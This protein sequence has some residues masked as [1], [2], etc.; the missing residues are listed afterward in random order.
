MPGRLPR[1]RSFLRAIGF[2][3]HDA[4]AA[5]TGG[6][7]PD[8]FAGLLDPPVP[9]SRRLPCLLVL[10]A[11][12]VYIHF[13][14]EPSTRRSLELGW[15]GH[16]RLFRQLAFHRHEAVVLRVVRSAVTAETH[17]VARRR[18]TVVPPVA[19]AFGGLFILFRGRRSAVLATVLVLAAASIIDDAASSLPGWGP[20]PRLL[21]HRR[22]A[23]T[24]LIG[25]ALG[26]CA[27]PP[28]YPQPSR[29][30]GPFTRL[31]H[32]RATVGECTRSS[33]SM[34]ATGSSI[35]K[36]ASP[37]SRWPGQRSSSPASTPSPASSNDC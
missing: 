17:V 19:A 5:R 18:G 10:L 36:P 21:R 20:R 24:L 15:A 9:P 8:R 26:P 30:S 29:R 34:T 28:N 35:A 7:R 4:A 32:R 31:R 37:C 1:G 25:S 12:A 33:T 3:H 22:R 23:H 6:D 11:I 27:G 2:S 13:V 16:S 14:A